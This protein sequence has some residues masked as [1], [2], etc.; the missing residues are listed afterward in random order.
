MIYLDRFMIH[1]NI[2]QKT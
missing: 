1:H 2:I